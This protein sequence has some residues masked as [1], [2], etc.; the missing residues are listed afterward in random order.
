MDRHHTVQVSEMP[1]GI[2]LKP[3]YDMKPDNEL[4]HEYEHEKN[5]VMNT[6]ANKDR[7]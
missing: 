3:K 7:L 4:K 5:Y 2:G 6:K 1:C